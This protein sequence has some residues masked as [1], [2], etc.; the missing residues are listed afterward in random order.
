MRLSAIGCSVLVLGLWGCGQPVRYEKI[1]GPYIVV[2]ADV[3]EDRH[4][5]YDLGDGAS[6]GRVRATVVGVGH[7]RHYIT[8]QRQP[9]DAP[10]TTE[11]YYVVRELDGRH[12]PAEA[13]KG[14]FDEATFRAEV[15]RL[16]LPDLKPVH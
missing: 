3:V 13:V 7:D 1:D 14:P 16:D 4:L 8:V 5:S 9:K 12:A 6:I 10:Q 2:A 11:Y 15:A